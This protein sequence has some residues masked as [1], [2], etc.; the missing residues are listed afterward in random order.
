MKCVRA[1][2]ANACVRVCV[3]VRETRNRLI[4]A[5]S[6]I[7]SHHPHTVHPISKQRIHILYEFFMSFKTRATLIRSMLSDSSR[8]RKSASKDNRMADKWNE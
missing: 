3:C 1:R 5:D 2:Q 6:T 8:K 4:A 7:G